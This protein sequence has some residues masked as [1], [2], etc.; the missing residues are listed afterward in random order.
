VPPRPPV[1][2]HALLA[3]KAP[4]ACV[5]RRGPSA[6]CH[7]ARWDLASDTV[8]HG[9]WIRATLYPE[10]CGLSSDGS[11]LAAFILSAK[12]GIGERGRYFA[13]S[14]VP[15]LHAL[16]AWSTNSTWTTGAHFD[17]D[18]SLTLAGALC[19]AEPTHGSYPG[20]VSL[21]PIDKQWTRARLQRELHTG[22]EE[23]PSS[24]PWLARVP[25]PIASTPN[26][27]A[28]ERRSQHDPRRSLVLVSLGEK[29][30]EYYLRTSDDTLT[31]LDD[32]TWAEWHPLRATHL[33]A[34]TRTGHLALLQPEPAPAPEPEPEPE[35][36]WTYDMNTPQPNPTSAP[37]WAHHWP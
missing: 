36:V 26:A 9:A 30:R 1:R 5:I 16:A 25:A 7:I 22:W 13:V 8:E 20:R 3:T 18:G 12:G 28:I 29:L 14:R 23:V 11:L 33:I 27:I 31:P 6:W 15:W 24:A 17:D 19:D 34:T 35:P 2:L 10:R 21:A 32:L 4:V 37:E